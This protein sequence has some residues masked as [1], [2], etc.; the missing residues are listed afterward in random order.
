[1]C[2]REK[3]SGEGGVE[4]HDGGEAALRTLF[5]GIFFKTFF[6]I[7]FLVTL[8]FSKISFYSDIFQ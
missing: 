2:V 6:L 1:M 4:H 3:G 5:S 8:L 7:V